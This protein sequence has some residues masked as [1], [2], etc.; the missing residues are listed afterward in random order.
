MAKGND[1]NVLQHGIEL[2]IVS[3]I[4]LRPL[5]LTCT[6]TMAPREHCDDPSRDRRLRHW[7]NVDT[8]TPLVA[9]AYRD[10]N[11]SLHSYPNTS[12]LVASQVGNADLRGDL[13]EV[14]PN[15]IN[16]LNERWDDHLVTV[17]GQSWRTGLSDISIPTVND[18]WLFTMDPMTFVSNSPDADDD[19][20][21]RPN[22]IDHLIRFFAN[23][24]TFGDHW[25]ISIF[26]FELRRGPGVNRYELFLN[27][28]E[29]LG[30]SLGLQHETYEVSYGNPHVG[31]VFS[32]SHA[33]LNEIRTEWNT[34]HNV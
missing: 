31:S 16:A 22:D 11:A 9:K 10:T 7:L 29:R 21:L 1:G 15:K 13:F 30:N 27:E 19:H 26:C 25:V 12:E 18:A 8:E 14:C 34:L 17:R 33:M 2:A 23:L 24:G 20:N 6:H 4:E 3:A 28:M 5:F 32:R